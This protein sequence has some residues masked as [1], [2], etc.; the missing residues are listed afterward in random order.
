MRDWLYELRNSKGMTLKQMGEKLGISESYYQ[1]VEQGK[2]QK[3][4]DIALIT[5][6][7]SATGKREKVIVDMELAYRRLQEERTTAKDP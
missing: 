1:Q 2:R 6:I 5:R 4:M 3:N 7:A